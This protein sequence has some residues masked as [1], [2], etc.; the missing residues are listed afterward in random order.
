MNYSFPW[1]YDIEDVIDIA[2]K[3]DEIVV[4]NRGGYTVLDYSVAFVDTFPPINYNLTIEEIYEAK[5]MREF[6]GLVFSNK[7]GFIIRRPY[8]KFFNYGERE[9]TSVVNP[10]LR[11]TILDKLDGSMISPFI[12]ENE[13]IWGTRLVAEEFHKTVKNLVGVNHERLVR[14]MN[15]LERTCMFEYIGPENR[16][17]IGYDDPNLVLTGMRDIF[18][19]DYIPYHQLKAY[20]DMYGV[21]VVDRIVF[22]GDIESLSEITST[23]T[24]E[25]GYVICFEDGHRIKMKSDWYVQLHKVKSLFTFEKDVVRLILDG[26]LDDLLPVLD[27]ADKEKIVAYSEKLHQEV[28][29]LAKTYC[30]LVTELQKTS[31]TKKDFAL[32]NKNNN[33]TM[34]GFVFA[35]LERDTV[36]LHDATEYLLDKIRKNTS[37]GPKWIEFK[38]NNGLEL[39]W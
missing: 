15:S 35:F 18:N 9:E 27:D 4:A 11:H 19:G 39:K 5:V 28:E 2:N 23:L 30:E 33:G 29:R 12:H 7:T 14:D 36:T 34:K 38:S 31:T 37:S 10:K 26:Q 13:I 22:N 25:E 17:V 8:H 1:I 6:R 20:G 24:S 16:I 21:P 3:H 32:N